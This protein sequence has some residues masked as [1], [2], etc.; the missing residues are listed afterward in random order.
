MI[1]VCEIHRRGRI[2]MYVSD[3]VTRSAIM[4][5]NKTKSFELETL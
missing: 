5:N 3:D 2:L 4:N 1:V